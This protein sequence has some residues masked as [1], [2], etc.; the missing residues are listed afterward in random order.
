MS[1]DGTKVYDQS[2]RTLDGDLMLHIRG[3]Q[4]YGSIVCIKIDT[5]VGLEL[6]VMLTPDEAREVGLKLMDAATAA[7]TK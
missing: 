4:Q 1:D 5:D 7:G 6:Q 2:V 3:Y